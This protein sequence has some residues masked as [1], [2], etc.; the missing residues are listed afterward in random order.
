MKE[1]AQEVKYDATLEEKSQI[2]E[3]VALALSQDAKIVSIM[4]LKYPEDHYQITTS[5]SNE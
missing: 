1:I 4:R 5:F 3:R 2:L